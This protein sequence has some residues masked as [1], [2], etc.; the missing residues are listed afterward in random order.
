MNAEIP[1]WRLFSSKQLPS[2]WLLQ[3]E[4]TDEWFLLH[5]THDAFAR[6]CPIPAHP[7]VRRKYL[8]PV[9]G[10]C[11]LASGVPLRREWNEVCH[12]TD[13]RN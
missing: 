10:Y 1:R 3:N 7:Q 9:P 2:N 13:G 6:R 4:D 5:M 8:E 11:F 12:G